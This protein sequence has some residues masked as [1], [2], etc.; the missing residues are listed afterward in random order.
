VAFHHVTDDA[1]IAME[2]EAVTVF[3]E[4][5]QPKKQHFKD[6]TPA[7]LEMLITPSATAQASREKIT[8]YKMVKQEVEYYK[9]I[10][11]DI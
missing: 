7:L 8:P 10:L 9:N 6:L 4:E 3:P 5:P 2:N 11:K 1:P